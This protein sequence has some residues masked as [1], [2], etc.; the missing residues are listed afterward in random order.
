MEKLT[1]TPVDENFNF[2]QDFKRQAI[3]STKA[4]YEPI[5][6]FWKY[7]TTPGRKSPLKDLWKYM[8]TPYPDSVFRDHDE[9]KMP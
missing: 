8:M 1:K 5:P 7:I 9:L 4:F 2:W 6:L 3:R